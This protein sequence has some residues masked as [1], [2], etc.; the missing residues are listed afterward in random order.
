MSHDDF[1]E[2]ASRRTY[3]APY[4]EKTKIPTIQGYQERQ[5]E[6]QAES[7]ATV[8]P[9]V[10]ENDPNGGEKP[11]AVDTAK[12]FLHL[13]SNLGDKS[14]N[15][16]QPYT[17]S[18]RNI[19]GPAFKEGEAN[20][21]HRDSIADIDQ[22]GPER[23]K[24]ALKDTSEAVDTTS[25]PKQKRKNMAHIRRDYAP[26]EVTDPVTHLKVKVHDTT[27][28]ELKTVPENEP[29]PGLHSRSATG[30]CA[31]SKS[32]SDLEREAEEQQGTHQRMKMLFPPPNFN[33]TREEIAGVYGFALTAGLASV[34]AATLCLLLAS[35][36][37][38]G[39]IRGPVSWFR[40]LAS[41]SFLLIPGTFLGGG[42]IW[43]LRHWLNSRI[44][45]IWEDELWDAAKLQ[46]K[47]TLNSP[48]PE[49]T[50]WLK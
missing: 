9:K 49:S 29:P 40:V 17:S 2:S 23:T 27:S 1:D 8:A 31:A 41:S 11:S 6:R 22:D 34:L 44:K 16:D 24:P 43:G 28:K 39:G 26:R 5:D 15:E 14:V 30:A 25:D 10:E 50:Q 32:T 21:D 12:N 42:I 45:S 46:E 7:E 19:G 4:S 33:A 18:N 35:H 37:L 38:N 20:N 13:G 36:L 3:V 48:T 47:Q